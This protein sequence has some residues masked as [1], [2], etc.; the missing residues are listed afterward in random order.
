MGR[1][2]NP[3]FV[4]VDPGKLGRP[5]EIWPMLLQKALAKMYSTYESLFHESVENLM[6]ELTGVLLQRIQFNRDPNESGELML[7]NHLLSE[8]DILIACEPTCES[9]LPEKYYTLAEIK[10][11][12]HAHFGEEIEL[13]L[14]STEKDRE[15]TCLLLENIH[16]YFNA[17][18]LYKMDDSY[19][20]VGCIIKQQAG[21]MSLRAFKVDA[22]GSCL[23]SVIQKDRKRFRNNGY[24]YCWMR[25][26]L[27][28]KD[29]AGYRYIGG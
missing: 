8:D 28:C 16:S 25:V 5:V 4:G 18:L 12:K 13:R 29:L 17:A 14:I 21:S 20:S 1:T 22:Y 3:V 9:K 24:K 19:Y 6:Q 10:K 23:F 26:I 27:I 11:K 15:S 7:K 2:W